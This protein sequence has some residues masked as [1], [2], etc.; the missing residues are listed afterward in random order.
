MSTTSPPS[1]LAFLLPCEQLLVM[2]V[3]GLVMVV[4]VVVPD[5]CPFGGWAL[6]H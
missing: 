4:V 3:G 5:S 1:S 6:Q 2:A